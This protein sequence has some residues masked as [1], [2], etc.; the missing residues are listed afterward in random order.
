MTQYAFQFDPVLLFLILTP[1]ALAVAGWTLQMACAISAVE[2]PDYWQSLLCVFLVSVANVLLRFW[3]NI[4]VPDPGLGYQL[5]WPLGMTAAII[6]VMVRVGPFSAVVVAICQG[7]ICA[8]IYLFV[9]MASQTL[10]GVL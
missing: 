4:S 9:S 6:A 2:P 10:A 7:A 3:V 8:G 5:L 1:L